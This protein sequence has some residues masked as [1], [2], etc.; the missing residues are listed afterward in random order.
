MKADVYRVL[1]KPLITEKVSDMAVLGKYSFQIKPKANKIMVKKAI[2]ALYNVKVRDV[3]IINVVGKSVR[4][5]RHTGKRSDWK[6]AIV[7]LAPGE[8]L[9]IYEGV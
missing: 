5:G 6:K 8:K 2:S 9:E 4:Y 3:R 1:V 7:T